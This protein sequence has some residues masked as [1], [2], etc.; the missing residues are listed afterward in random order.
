MPVTPRILGG[1]FLFATSICAVSSVT[2]LYPGTVLDRIW[3]FKPAEYASMMAHAV[4]VGAG[5][6]VLALAFAATAWGAFHRRRWGHGLAVG[7]F[8]VNALADASRMV[9]GSFAD[10]ALGV[11]I[12]GAAII[13]LTRPGVRALFSN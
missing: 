9:S 8:V 3:S 13:W 6:A 1:F 5:F 12:S 11:V 2:F 10:G 4:W 7:V